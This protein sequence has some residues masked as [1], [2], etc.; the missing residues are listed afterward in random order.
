MFDLTGRVAVVT[1]ASAGLGRGEAIALARQGADVAIL[2]RRADKLES[3]AEEIRAFGHKCLPIVC[4]VTDLDQIKSA[5]KQVIETFGKV[6]IL[7]NNAGG[8]ACMPLEEMTD[9]A[10]MHNINL[11]LY[12][13]FRCTREF[14]K[15]MLKRGYGR[16]INIA[17][18][19]G[20]VGL[21]EVPCIGY[22]SAKGGII[23]FTRGAATEWATKGITV[24]SVCPGFFPSEANSPEAMES[25]HDMIVRNTPMGRPG[26]ACTDPEKGSELDSTIIFLAADESSYVTGATIC[27]DGGWTCH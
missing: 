8:G 12:A 22:Q 17:S 11:E 18:I 27:C 10:Y 2:A 5:V 15:E 1:G 24:N 19:L 20:Y 7:V 3:V 23:N 4:D 9:E 26:I 13:T 16:V 6:D 21:G 14:G 25:M